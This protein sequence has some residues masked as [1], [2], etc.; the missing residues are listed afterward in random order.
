[1]Q[2]SQPPANDALDQEISFHLQQ[3]TDSYI[4]R[5][6]SP[7]EARR[8]ARLDFG[9]PTQV[10]Q[11]VREVHLSPALD[12]AAF[13]LRAAL[14]SLRHAPGFSIAVIATLAL[15][16]GANSAMFSVLDAVVLR[17]LPYPAANQLVLITERNGHQHDTNQLVAPIRLED[18][19]RLNSTFQSISGSYK[20]DVT[21][22]SGP[23][24][25]R[26]TAAYVAPRFLSVMGVSPLLGRDFSPAEAHF[27]GP[28]AALISYGLW[29]R[30]FQSD[31]HVL[32]RTL[33]AGQ[34]TLPIIGVMPPSF[35]FPD[36]QFDLWMVSPP[37]APYAQN[38]SSTWFNVVGR[39]KPGVTPAQGLAN[40]ATVQHQLGMQFP[41]TDADLRIEVTPLKETTIGNIRDSLWLLY[42]SVSLLLL[43]ACSN[44]AAL[45]LARTTDREHEISVRFSLGAPRRGIIAQLL[46]ETFL[47][48]LLGSLLGLA[49]AAG[50]T[51]VFHLLAGAL[52]RKEEISIN[53]RVVLYSLLC[54]VGT[55]LLCGL[56]PA[57]RGTRR[58]L[59]Q[60]LATSS[61]TQTAARSPMQ[62]LLVGVQV[63]LAVVLLTSAGLLVRSLQQLGR[64]S[65]GFD[66]AHVL[67]F[68]I[69]GS[70]GETAD[71]GRLIQRID[72]TLNA[73]RTTPGVEAAATAS[74]MPG[75]PGRYQVDY[76]RDGQTGLGQLIS[77]AG[78]LVSAGYFD[79]MHIPLILGRSC[80]PSS[81]N[82][83]AP[84]EY[85]VNRTFADRFFADTPPLGHMLAVATDQ[86]FAPPGR[87]VGVVAD[88]REQ[89][90][91]A[92][93]VPTAY[94]CFSAPGPA[95]IFLVRTHGDPAQFEETIRRRVRELE[96][97]RSV[98]AIVPLQ[99][100]LDTSFQDD[101][102]RTIVL[103]SF[104]SMAVLL[105]CIGLYGTLSYLARVRHREMGVRLT[106]GAS[107][108]QVAGL[109]LR[110]GI[111]VALLGCLAGGIASLLVT[112]L[113]ASMLYEVSP[114]DPPTYLGVL[115]F[116]LVAAVVACAVPAHRAA[117]IEP[118]EALRAG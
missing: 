9:G 38:R 67:T 54:A 2:P 96:P 101:R 3:L 107:R 49:L 32:G 34:S 110:Q 61:R 62:W 42:G 36:R 6:L 114:L 5:G 43:I 90:L 28:P 89:G 29:Q 37:D 25:E 98:Y 52:P 51:H 81:A 59:A 57:V 50:I 103:V 86:N 18:W 16:I 71:M 13:Y 44:I 23:L 60:S 12:A 8:Q 73:L 113:L 91:N 112:R 21:E 26:L 64:V 22:T 68:Q 40:L 92:S 77:A 66:A 100:Q 94:F 19:N 69:T 85:L 84:G 20:D 102:L 72:R 48:A 111:R 87:I 10:K 17:P 106:L 97:G 65:P 55:T 109:F 75:L 15:G 30:R 4:A 116:T 79:T 31:P 82:P 53:W 1:M 63:T 47:L 39:L 11:S 27:G 95:P 45:L 88:A 46:A 41:T 83:N 70:Y 115:L 117:R 118:T 105:A 76:S 74:S 80:G 24:P 93:P 78:R 58:Q 7:Q 33:H 56:Y 99:Q 108:T 14:R 104:A 35:L